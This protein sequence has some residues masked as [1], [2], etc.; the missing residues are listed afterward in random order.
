[1]LNF[2]ASAFCYEHISMCFFSKIINVPL[3]CAGVRNSVLSAVHYLS[4][5]L[6]MLAWIFDVFTVRSSMNLLLFLQHNIYQLDENY[7][8]ASQPK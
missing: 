3:C 2:N 1:M 5:L 6:Y 4:M 8:N 7:I